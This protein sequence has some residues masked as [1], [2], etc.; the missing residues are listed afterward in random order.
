MEKYTRIHLYNHPIVW[1]KHKFKK[2]F[3]PRNI[4]VPTLFLWAAAC[5]ALY[6]DFKIVMGDRDKVI[7]ILGFLLFLFGLINLWHATALQ[8]SAI[9]IKRIENA[10]V[11]LHKE[12]IHIIRDYNTRKRMKGNMDKATILDY[13]RTILKNIIEKHMDDVHG[14]SVQACVKYLKSE[15]VAVHKT[16][17]EADTFIKR[18]YPIR[19]GSDEAKRESKA[20]DLDRSYVFLKLMGR[21][22]YSFIYVKNVE[23]YDSLELE[24]LGDIAHDV[25]VRAR[26]YKYKTFLAFP[27]RTG[28]I[29]FN[30][31]TGK[32]ERPFTQE[33]IGML[34]FDLKKKFG[35]FNVEKY[36]IHLMLCISDLLSDIVNDLIKCSRN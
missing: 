24:V 3:N 16:E 35:F 2:G 11:M 4:S 28:H 22:R 32:P 9:R 7:I 29:K 20:E 12:V 8:K 19:Y 27:I 13:V 33:D 25:A 21:Q 23:K 15:P 1:I 10:C 36:E 34:S 17:D 30:I 18:L 5:F 26:K 14:N 31:K 6:S